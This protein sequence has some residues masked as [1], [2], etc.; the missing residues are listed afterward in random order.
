LC[1]HWLAVPI[2][3]GIWLKISGKDDKPEVDC[4]RGK[5]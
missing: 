3:W 1:F 5:E 2:L 4:C